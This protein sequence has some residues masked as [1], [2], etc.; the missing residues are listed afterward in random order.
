MIADES[1]TAELPPIYFATNKR[2]DPRLNISK[3]FPKQ[4]LPK[5]YKYIYRD[6]DPDIFIMMDDISMHSYKKILWAR[7]RF[8]WRPVL[9]SRTDEIHKPLSD[10]D[11]SF[12][13]HPTK[14][15]NCLW[16]LVAGNPSMEYLLEGKK[17]EDTQKMLQTPKTRFCNFIYRRDFP[18]RTDFCKLLA[19][20]KKVDCPGKSLNNMPSIPG[21][22]HKALWPSKLDFLSHYKF[23]ITFER[24]SVESYVTEKIYHAFFTGSIPIYWGCLKIAEYFNPAAFIN[25]HDYK[26]FEDVVE[27]VKEIDNNPRLYEEYRNAPIVLP[28]SRLHTAMQDINKHCDA[29]FK[30]TLTRRSWKRQ[31][32]RDMWRMGLLVSSNLLRVRTQ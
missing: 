29:I 9:V 21:D 14:G 10:V 3:F 20:Y 5:Q 11:F 31:R 16:V 28:N 18:T 25:C 8:G 27:R 19:Q 23:T 26:N 2:R 7:W 6:H 17:S 1:Q 13:F 12:S 4:Y 24:P 22:A 30:E 15:K 32:I